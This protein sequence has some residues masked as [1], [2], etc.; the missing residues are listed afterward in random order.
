MSSFVFL[1]HNK[2][3][4]NTLQIVFLKSRVDSTGSHCCAFLCINR[5]SG[6]CIHASCWCVVLVCSQSCD[7]YMSKAL[8]HLIV[9]EY[10]SIRI[11]LFLSHSLFL[12]AVLSA[13]CDSLRRH[14]RDVYWGHMW[15]GLVPGE[16]GSTTLVLSVRQP[17]SQPVF[18]KKAGREWRHT[19]SEER[20]PEW[21]AVRQVFPPVNHSPQNR[22][23]DAGCL[24]RPAG[25]NWVKEDLMSQSLHWSRFLSIIISDMMA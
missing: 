19:C 10:P 12:A 5:C 18:R 21:T 22:S 16:H 20:E 3:W 23:N 4:K 1:W 14:G 25:W 24:K 2:L 17:V 11:Q 15:P 7:A 6:M 13:G 8:R 9:T